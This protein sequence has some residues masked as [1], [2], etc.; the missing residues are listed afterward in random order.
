MKLIVN[1]IWASSDVFMLNRTFQV[2]GE[3]KCRKTTNSFWDEKCSYK[4]KTWFKAY[5]SS[6]L[7]ILWKKFNFGLILLLC[8]ILSFF[9]E[10]TA[11]YSQLLKKYFRKEK[12][13]YYNEKIKFFTYCNRI[14]RNSFFLS[15]TVPPR[16]RLEPADT[17][18]LVGRSVS[19]HCQA[20]GFPQPQIRWEKAT[21]KYICYCFNVNENTSIIR[22]NRKFQNE[23]KTFNEIL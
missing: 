21:G 13:S 11:S 5:C 15:L 17:S 23:F 16:W 20:D 8:K 18:V 3:Y 1:A 9:V 10:N 7:E 4:T 22:S 6:L 19:L 2:N 12:I 14:G